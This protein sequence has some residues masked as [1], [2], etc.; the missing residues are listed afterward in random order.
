[1]KITIT[2]PRTTYPKTSEGALKEP[3]VEDKVIHFLE[4]EDKK[5]LGAF[6]RGLAESIDPPDKQYR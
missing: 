3:V 4:S 1:M 6:L 2:E 5:V